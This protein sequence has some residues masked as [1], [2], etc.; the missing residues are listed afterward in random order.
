MVSIDTIATFRCLVGL[1][2]GFPFKPLRSKPLAGD[3]KTDS[4]DFCIHKREKRLGHPGA[5][6]F[7]LPR[8]GFLD[9]VQLKSGDRRQSL[10]QVFSSGLYN[11]CKAG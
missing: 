10:E 1:V 7:D 11:S 2:L 5:S 8:A 6:S 3:L 9:A 4:P